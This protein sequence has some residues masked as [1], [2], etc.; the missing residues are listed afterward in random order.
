MW[1][2]VWDASVSTGRPVCVCDP[3]LLQDNQGNVPEQLV[4]FH[5]GLPTDFACEKPAGRSEIEIM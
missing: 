5:A 4:T 2:R 3:G 1:E